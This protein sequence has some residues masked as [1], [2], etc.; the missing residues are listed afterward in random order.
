VSSQHNTDAWTP[1]DLAKP[2]DSQLLTST[3]G[4]D[5]DDNSSPSSARHVASL[6]RQY[7]LR[8]RERSLTYSDREQIGNP[9]SRDL[10]VT[11]QPKELRWDSPCPEE[12]DAYRGFKRRVQED[13]ESVNQPDRRYGCSTIMTDR[14]AAIG[15]DRRICD[16]GEAM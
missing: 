6:C 10:L 13:R 1:V 14:Q 3:L 2:F 5:P 9:T 8:A 12:I 4:L 7:G 16:N 15:Q 11:D